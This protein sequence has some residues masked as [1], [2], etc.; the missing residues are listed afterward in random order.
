MS[1]SYELVIKSVTNAVSQDITSV[2]KWQLAGI[3]VAEFYG[4]ETALEEVKAQFI[5]DAILPGIGKH[6]VNV[7][8]IELPRK[9]SKE[10]KALDSHNVALWE[11]ANQAKKDARA[12]AHTMFT[13]VKGYA[14]PAIKDEAESTPKD[15]KTKINETIANLVKACQKAEE[16][17]FDITSVIGAL[18]NV[19]TVVNK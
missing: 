4:T 11:K 10:Y 15:L 5:A 1:T 6:H 2:G 3:T 14:F 12:V 16:A 19:L 8:N 18:E 9:G 7:L 13:R 17:T